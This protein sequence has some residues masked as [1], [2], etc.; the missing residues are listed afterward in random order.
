MELELSLKEDAESEDITGDAKDDSVEEE[1]RIIREG[2]RD[3][4]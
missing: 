2:R 3:S 4:K 1:P